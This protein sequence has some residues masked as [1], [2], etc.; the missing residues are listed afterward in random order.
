METNQRNVVLQLGALITLYLSISFTLLILFG[1]IDTLIVSPVEEPW[2]RERAR[3]NIRLGLAMVL[4]FFPTFLF[5]TR[6]IQQYRRLETGA[7]YQTIT[8][9][10]IYLSLLI[11]GLILLGTLVTVI[12]NFFNGDLTNRFL[13]KAGSMLVVLTLACFYY[14]KDVEGYWL[15]HERLSV[16]I[17]IMTS[18]LVVIVATLG[19]MFTDSP[20]TVRELRL[21]AQQ[22]NDLQTIQW[23]IEEYLVIH[24]TTTPPAT[25][26]DLVEFGPTL[27]TAPEGRDAYSY[28]VSE[29]GFAL[30]ATFRH[31][32]TIVNNTSPYLPK[33]RGISIIGS[34][35]WEY[36]AGRYCFERRIVNGGEV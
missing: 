29:A 5:L 28:E 7:L 20:Q 10:L 35:H 26:A 36:Q 34:D 23:G 15:N 11:G 8:K 30:C 1:V 12:Y 32:S 2:E 18:V 27:P 31:H 19:I 33:S 24:A 13:L 16:S 22:I 21:D 14:L 9:W 25:L 3:E 6:K 4:V 17:G